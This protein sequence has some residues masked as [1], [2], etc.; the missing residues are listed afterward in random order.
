MSGSNIYLFDLLTGTTK[1]PSEFS[2]FVT[3]K[4]RGRMKNPF[5]LRI[6]NSSV[7]QQ[8][9][10]RLGNKHQFQ[11]RENADVPENYPNF[12]DLGLT[13]GR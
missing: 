2:L 1:L 11:Y 8:L 5:L 9:G 4:T 12:G 13:D 7:W 3:F 6:F 10:I